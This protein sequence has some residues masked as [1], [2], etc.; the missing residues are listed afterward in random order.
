MFLFKGPDQKEHFESPSVN[1]EQKTDST[2]SSPE[3]LSKIF[4]NIADYEYHISL[5]PETG[6]Y[7]SP[8]RRHHIRTYYEPGK[9]HMQNRLDSTG[10]KWELAF[11][12]RGL[13]ADGVRFN[14]DVA[15][16]TIEVTGNKIDFVYESFT[17]QYIN[18]PTG[19]RQ[20]FIIHKVPANTNELAVQLE[21]TGM[22]AVQHKKGTIQFSNES[23]TL[24][25]SNLK[26]WDA[27]G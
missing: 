22:Q 7:Q 11:K 16:P 24:S 1:S 14:K 17:E 10:L 4:Q 15:K 6:K 9:W 20:N 12:T 23:Q 2:Y 5:D 25:Y 26:A 27:T 21:F 3:V 19:V 18:D 13:H 8:N